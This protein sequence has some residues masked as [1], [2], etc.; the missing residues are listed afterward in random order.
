M[1]TKELKLLILASGCMLAM[2]SVD[3]VEQVD[4]QYVWSFNSGEA[5]PIGYDQNTGKPDDLTYVR[6]NY[7]AGFFDRINNAL[8]EGIVN[9]AFLVGDNGANITLSED[10][11]VFV[12]FIHEGAGY[13]NSFGYFTY[14]A[15]NPPS[16]IWEVQETI[17]FP[18]LSYP[19]LT[20]GHQVKLGSFTAGTSIGFFLA[21]NAFWYDTGVKPFESP[22]YYSL[23][24]LNNEPEL[25]K[26]HNVMLFDE[27]S[28]EMIIGFEDLPRTWGDNDFND[29][30]FAVSANPPT[31]IIS[32][33]VVNMPDVN[34]SDADGIFDAD[35]EFPNDYTKAFSA[36]FPSNQD[37]VT[38]AFEDNWPHVGDFDMNDLVVRE[39]LK[40]IYNANGDIS[41]MEISGFI[42]A[43]GASHNNGFAVRLMGLSPD[44]VASSAITID[45]QSF[46]K[47]P[48][49][50]QTDAV[51]VLWSNTTDFTSRDDGCV[52]FNTLKDCPVYDP[53]PF[54]LSI[55]FAYAPANL[56][57]S[58]LD[59]FI[60]RT[61]NRAREIHFADY[62]PTDLFDETQF[63]RFD[64]T[65]EPMNDRYFRNDKNLPWALKITTDWCYPSEYIDIVWAYPFYEKWVETSGVEAEQWYYASDR[66]N[67]YFCRNE[68]AFVPVYPATD[69]T[70]KV[71]CSLTEAVQIDANMYTVKFDLANNGND[72]IVGWSAS[73]DLLD[74]EFVGSSHEGAVYEAQTN[75]LIMANNV[76]DVLLAPGQSKT[77]EVVMDAYDPEASYSCVSQ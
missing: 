29:A 43:R 4:G 56:L 25:L 60:F 34:D 24:G 38:L 16:S 9:Q 53:V 18:N 10:G 67:H 14:D 57:H 49:A 5:W 27:I 8:P 35:D 20:S 72:V 50:F 44:I 33:D 22:Y 65:S 45:N 52:Q 11:E 7:D 21:A 69:L 13:Q 70:N 71:A 30:V 19:H 36:F 55:D 6:D 37:W 68:N 64:D 48:E 40:T 63:G 3:A 12:T 39:R 1:I 17:V 54:T 47:T 46:E 58:A 51:I 42:D 2:N 41:G 31:A 23:Q 76:W 26:Q 74:A 15:A 59:F 62:P 73:V 28:G 32:N 61:E 66:S 75:S 77:I